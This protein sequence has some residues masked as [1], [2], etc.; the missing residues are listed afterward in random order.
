MNKEK[1]LTIRHLFSC[2]RLHR[3]RILY[4]VSPILSSASSNHSDTTLQISLVLPSLQ[5]ILP[6]ILNLIIIN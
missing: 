5:K 2:P 3:L 6:T 4:K 1:I